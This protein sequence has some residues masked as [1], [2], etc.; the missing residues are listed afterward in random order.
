MPRRKP[1]GTS[2]AQQELI[3]ARILTLVNPDRC[4]RQRENPRLIR[5]VGS[6]VRQGVHKTLP[7]ELVQI[8]A[9]RR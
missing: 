5:L 8:R 1:A 4:S 9:L 7:E 6:D 3:T 2:D